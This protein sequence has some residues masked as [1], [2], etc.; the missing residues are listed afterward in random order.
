MEDW[1]ELK[2]NMLNIF[3]S[4]MSVFHFAY[5]VHLSSIFAAFITGIFCTNYR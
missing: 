5:P 1:H 2:Y 3:L 4:L